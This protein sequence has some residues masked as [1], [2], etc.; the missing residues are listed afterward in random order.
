M[1]ENI[2]YH[3]G[4][5]M[6]GTAR[7]LIIEFPPLIKLSTKH[8]GEIGWCAHVTQKHYHWRAKPR[9]RFY[10]PNNARAS[11]TLRLTQSLKTSELN[12]LWDAL[13]NHSV[14]RGM[15]DGKFASSKSIDNAIV[16]NVKVLKDRLSTRTEEVKSLLADLEAAQRTIVLLGKPRVQE[17]T[18]D[19][20]LEALKRFNELRAK[21]LD[22]RTKDDL[23]ER[24]DT[25]VA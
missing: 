21:N 4:D 16:E 3:I 20:E 1:R 6:L 12:E 14:L 9:V 2:D 18:L 19:H 24:F 17:L 22:F 5:Y 11:I 7:D 8:L 10:D 23:E 13:E 25:R 15:P